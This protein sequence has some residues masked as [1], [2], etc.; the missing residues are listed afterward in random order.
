MAATGIPLPL[1]RANQLTLVLGVGL[2]LV[3]RAPQLLWALVA[4]LAVGLLGGA[5]WHPVFAV[6]RL[7]LGRRLAGAPREDAAMQRFNQTLATV[8]LLLSQGAF[9]LGWETVGWLLA[10]AVGL[11]AL[12][13]LG[14]YCVGCA[15]YLRLRYLRQR[16]VGQA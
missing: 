10:A 2:A 1:V 11:A 14:G 16:L 8:L 5:R 7:L 3:L 6:A 9:A 12:G 15:L 4:V 13:A